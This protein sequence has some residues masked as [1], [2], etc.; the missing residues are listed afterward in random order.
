MFVYPYPTHFLSSAA[1][2]TNIDVTFSE[3][4]Q[5]VDVTDLVLTGSGATGAVKGTPTHQGANVWR[6][7]VSNLQNG[8]VNVSLAP[9]ANDIEDAS[10]NDLAPVS[11]SFTVNDATPT[12]T[13]TTPTPADTT[14]LA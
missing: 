13:G 2:S 3:T 6:F 8:P 1:T 5:G 14:T 12:P 9:D 10:G 4:V 7:P 11:W